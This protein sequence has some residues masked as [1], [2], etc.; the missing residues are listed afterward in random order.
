[1]FTTSNNGGGSTST[2]ATSTAA[3]SSSLTRS[4]SR[5]SPYSNSYGAYS[6]TNVNPAAA[7]A[8]MHPQNATGYQDYSSMYPTMDMAWHAAASAAYSATLP[9]RGY[10]PASIAEGHMW[11]PQTH[12]HM[13]TFIPSNRY[14]L[15]YPTRL[16]HS[17]EVCVWWK[18][19][20]KYFKICHI[21]RIQKFRFFHFVLHYFPLMNAL[22]RW[23]TINIYLG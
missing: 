11:P 6:G 9:Y 21:F 3:S 12:P 10:D 13:N 17:S 1:M 22:L 7:A 16:R 19:P 5:G 14:I 4:A 18:Y 15:L 23:K 20:V 8:A 2:I